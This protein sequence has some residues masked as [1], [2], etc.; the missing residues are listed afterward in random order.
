MLTISTTRQPATDLGFLLHKNPE[1]V[2]EFSLPFGTCH[3]LYPE[4]NESRCTAAMFVN[5]DPVRLVRGKGEASGAMDQYVNDRPYTANSYMSVAIGDALGTALG[6]RCK[7]KPELVDEPLPLEIRIPVIACRGGEGRLVE[8]FGPLGYK[9]ESIHLQLDS[10]FPEWGESIY[11]DVKLSGSQTVRDCLRH[12][13]ILLPVLDAKKHYYMDKQEIDKLVAKGAGWLEQHPLKEW[14]VRSYLGRKPSLMLQALEQLSNAEEEIALIESSSTD[15]D[16][17]P[18]PRKQNLHQQRHDR[19]VEV[20]RDLAPKTVVDLG[21]GEGKLIRKLLR[22][23]DI[24]RILGMDVSLIDLEKAERK[25]HLEDAG[26]KLTERIQLIHGSLMY[27]DRRIEG[28]DLATVVE[29][30]EHLDAARLAAFEKVV[31]QFARPQTVLVTTPNREYNAVYGINDEL[32]HSDHR[33]EWTRDE[34]Q[35]WTMKICEAYGYECR[36]EGIGETHDTFGSPSQ[37][38]VFTR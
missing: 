33:F 9:V 28:F 6:G 38:G 8:L 22:I 26:P 21:C 31:F 32:R 16:L 14:I 29:V 27:R 35:S 10:Q 12:L 17:V 19:I 3:I 11:F 1:R 20:V 13:Y 5:I 36:V 30:I 37:M 18:E 15:E 25:L 24:T 23:K 34:F 2:H 7:Q 4:A